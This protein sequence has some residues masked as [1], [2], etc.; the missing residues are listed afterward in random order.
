MASRSSRGLPWAKLRSESSGSMTATA[1]SSGRPCERSI[2]ILRHLRRAASEEPVDQRLP[3]QDELA[4]LL[5]RRIRRHGLG[6]GLDVAEPAVEGRQLR[7]EI[8]DSDVYRGAA[9]AAGVLFSRFHEKTSEALPLP[10]RIHGQHAEVA[11]VAAE[12]DVDARR[13]RPF[14]LGEEERAPLE[15]LAHRR[16]RGALAVHEEALHLERG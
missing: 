4:G 13:E 14:P 6:T 5:E 9:G 1:F 3:H 15:H 11:V 10:R 8:D 7:A 16:R 12:L 2:D